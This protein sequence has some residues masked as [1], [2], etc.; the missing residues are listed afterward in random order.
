MKIL[1]TGSYGQLGR[2]VVKTAR[3][4]GHD[5]TAH[6]I[7]TLDITDRSQ[8]YTAVSRCEPDWVLNCAAYTAV[9]DCEVNEPRA[10][11]VNAA[12][13]A[14]LAAACDDVGAALLQVSTDY[15][16]SGELDKPLSETHP[17]NP[18]NAYGRTKLAGEIEA[19]KARHHLIVRTAWLY[20]HG[21][22]SFIEAIRRQL[23]SGCLEL[24]VVTDQLGCPTFCSDLAEALLD[25]TERSTEG[26][27]HAV[28]SGSVSWFGLAQ[29]IVRLLSADARVLPVTSDEFP[30]PAKRPR[31]SVLD[32][33]RLNQLIGRR[34]P[35][36]QDALARYLEPQ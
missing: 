15:V 31:Y 3:D 13:V 16:F 20:G 34:L 12:A 10:L 32:T 33:S 22:Q 17:T 4:R 24:R 21:G 11:A 23:D 19:E 30:R 28:N 29:E 1:I 18:I 35:D 27:V 8:V 9:D 2:A 14:G 26:I 6:D 36:W 7:D 25:L 5:T